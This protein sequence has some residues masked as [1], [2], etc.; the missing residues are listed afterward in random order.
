MTVKIKKLR[1]SI[2][3][4]FNSI[5]FCNWQSECF[6][7]NSQFLESHLSWSW[8][9]DP[10]VGR[11]ICQILFMLFILYKGWASEL[12]L[13]KN[14][15]VCYYLTDEPIQ[16]QVNSFWYP[17][18]LA[19]FW[20]NLHPILGFHSTGT[21]SYVKDGAKTSSLSPDSSSGSTSNWMLPQ[22]Y[23]L[24]LSGTS[25]SDGEETWIIWERKQWLSVKPCIIFDK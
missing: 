14:L 25:I 19:I 15:R 8:M 21:S 12:S 18:C 24:G 6:A 9:D 5:L 4:G 11:C 17:E 16:P 10:T 3:F 7:R 1:V 13:R 20:V 23:P 22:M 2:C